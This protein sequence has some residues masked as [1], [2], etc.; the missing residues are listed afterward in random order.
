MRKDIQP[1][2]WDTAVGGHVDYGESIEEALRR[3]VR[4]ELGVTDFVPE[5]IT[6]YIFESAIEKE[7]VNAFR[8]TYEGPITPDPEELEDGRFWRL[9][10]IEANLGKNLFTPNFEQEYKRLFSKR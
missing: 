1:G 10:E 6:A 9:D 8:T 5:F 3:E 4:E 2:K 7:L